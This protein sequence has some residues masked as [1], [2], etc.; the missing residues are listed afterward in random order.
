MKQKSIFKKAICFALVLVTLTST[1]VASFCAQTK[2]S[3]TVLGDTDLDGTLTVIDAALIQKMLASIITF[4]DVQYNLADV[5]KD[6]SVDVL[7]ATKIQKILCGITDD[8]DLP[9]ELVADDPNP[10]DALTKEVLK[11]IEIGFLN[12]VNEERAK[13]NLKPLTHDAHLDSASQVRSV[14]LDTLF[15]HSRPDGSYGFSAVNPSQYRF[16]T[17]G[18]NILAHAFSYSS[19]FTDSQIESIYTTMFNTF[20][21]SPPHYENMTSADYEDIGIGLYYVY[22][23]NSNAVYF[24]CANFF[25]R[26]Y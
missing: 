11:K 18:E 1:F 26:K 7:D 15:S 13:L 5:N 10:D 21:N 20:K 9:N 25:G 22:Y 12:L 3:D 24:Y 14:E 8:V 19:N 16:A 6:G 17:L 4:T 2:S 23:K